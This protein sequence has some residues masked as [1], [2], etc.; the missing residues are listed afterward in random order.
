MSNNQRPNVVILGGGTGMPVLLR[1]LKNKDINLTAIV[2]V[3][4]DGGSTGKIRQTRNIPAPGD[5]RNV[6]AALSNVEDDLHKL[7][8][9]RINRNNDLSGHALGNLLLVA[10]NDIVGDFN[11]AVQKVAKLFNVRANIYPVAKEPITLHAKMNDGS[12]VTGESTI[13]TENKKIEKVFVTPE[14]VKANAAAIQAIMTADLIVISPGSLYT[15]ILPNIIIDEIKHAIQTTSA[16]IVY[17]CNIMT[18]KGETDCYTASNHIQVIA[19]HLGAQRIDTIIVHNKPIKQKLLSI[20]KAEQSEPVAIDYEQL[21]QLKVRIVE[22]DVIDPAKAT[23]RHNNYKLA[24]M[25][26]K[27]AQKKMDS[28]IRK[29]NNVF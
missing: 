7:F 6:I 5:V 2:T 17:V 16:K 26:V 8:Q 3:A 27:M 23:I 13:P 24:D 14:K 4:D 1:G 19:N 11:V 15:S 28:R 9:Y 25:I 12:I 22:D 18:Q 10:T 20:Y 29:D 21:D